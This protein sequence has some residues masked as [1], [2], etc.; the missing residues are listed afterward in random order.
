MPTLTDVDEV[1]VHLRAHLAELKYLPLENRYALISKNN[2]LPLS[3]GYRF[4]SLSEFQKWIE[5]NISDSFRIYGELRD[6]H[7]I[8]VNEKDITP[9]V[10]CVI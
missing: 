8:V 10:A 5:K 2:G 9:S 1:E 4:K 3:N 6:V 7:R